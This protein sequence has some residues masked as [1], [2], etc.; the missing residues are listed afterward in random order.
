MFRCTT[1]RSRILFVFGLLVIALFIQ[2][3]QSALAETIK[4][5]RDPSVMAAAQET[6]VSTGSTITVE[7]TTL[8]PTSAGDP[9]DGACDLREAMQAA[10]TANSTNQHTQFNECQADPGPTFII[11][12]PSVAGQT[13]TLAHGDDILPFVNHELTITGPI[14][15]S[16]GGT[17]PVNPPPSNE[18]WDSRLFRTA[19]GGIFTLID[20]T[21]KKGFTVGG[22]GIILGSNNSTINLIGVSMMDNTVYG[23]GGAINTD[24]DLNILLSNFS[25]N[26]ALGRNSNDYT[27]N[28][29]TGFGGAIY[30]SGASTLSISLSNFSGN[31]A[32]KSGGAIAI[33]QGPNVSIADTNFLGNIAQADTDEF[34]GGGALYNYHGSISI[35]RS[36]FSANVTTNGRG[37]AIF[38]N[39]SAPALDISDSSF[40]ANVSGDNDTAGNGGAIYNEEDMTITRSTFNANVVLGDGLGGAITNNRAAVMK[41]TNTTFL[42]NA[43]VN[44]ISAA[45]KGGAIANIDNPYPVSSDTT[46]ELR[47]VTITENKAQ[48]GGGIYNE[49]LVQLW[50][51]IVDEGTVGG[52]GTCAGTAPEDKGHNL[53]N[54]GATCGATIN[55]TDP[56]LDV[57]KFNGGALAALVSRLPKDGSPAIDAGDNAVCDGPLVN[58]EDQRGSARPK[59]GD[60]DFSSACDI[61]AT[62]AGT[63]APGFGSDPVQPGPLA[64]GNAT[65]G[66]PATY[67]LSIIETGTRELTVAANISGPDAADFNINSVMP[68]VMPNGSPNYPLE[69]VCDPTSAT[70]GT[71]TATLSLTTSD[72]D[73]LTVDYDMTCVV[74]SVPTPGFGSY[75]EA[76]GPLD[77]GAVAVGTSSTQILELRETG[78]ADLSLAGYNLTGPNTADFTLDPPVTTLVDGA[79]PAPYQVTCTPTATGMRTAKL[80]ISTND[81][82]WPTAEFDLVCM[83]TAVQPTYLSAPGQALLTGTS[84]GSNG[85]YDVAVSPDSRFV[86]VTDYGD[87][88]VVA[89][90][91]NAFGGLELLHIYQDGVDGVSNLVQ[92]IFLTVSPD[93]RNLYVAAAGS[94]AIVTFSRDIDTGELAYM[95]AVVEGDGY[96]C[97]PIPCN[98]NINGLEGA[99]G[100][101]VSQDGRFVYVT[102]ITDDAL[103]VLRRNTT[104][105]DLRS[106]L[107][108]ANFVQSYTSADL[109]GV[110]GVTISPDGLHLYAAGFIGNDL[111]VFSRNPNDGQVTF[112]QARHD[113]DLISINPPRFL[114]GLAG[115]TN[116]VVSPDGAYVYVTGQVD[117][118]I[119]VFSRNGLDGTVTYLRSYDDD[120]G[121]GDGLAGA[122]GL[123]LSPD[124]HT[125]YATGFTDDSVV[126]F[127]REATTGLLK[128]LQTTT[129]PELDGAVAVAAAPDGT[130]VFALGYLQN[131]IVTLRKSNPAPQIDS[132]LPASAAG[133]SAGLT[134]T[135]RGQN[136]ASDSIVRWNGADR[137]ATYISPTELQVAVMAAD[138]PADTAVTT[139]S[140]AVINGTP[141]GGTA[142]AEFA[143]THGNELPIPAIDYISPQSLPAAASSAV[144]TVYGTNF[145][146]A[147]QVLWNGSARPT[148]YISSSELQFTISGDDLLNPG[149]AAISLVNQGS[150]VAQGVNGVNGGA[151]SNNSVAFTVAA[152]GQNPAPTITSL[153][154]ALS[155]ARGAASRPM[156]ILVTGH[157]FVEGVQAQWNGADRPTVL[158]SNTQLRVTL[159]AADLAFA[160]SG[161]LRVV[162]PE[163]GGGTSNTAALTIFPYGLFL[164]V[165]IR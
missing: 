26:V 20:I 7:T 140:V 46:V 160:G 33:Y 151:L 109:D 1:N 40:N 12:A 88:L 22:G 57:P 93:G 134:L 65:P 94:N 48:T 41:V 138:L 110:R 157:N 36:P 19:G 78:N 39:L 58:K 91:R 143:I 82:A 129:Q 86:Y 14:T 165:M 18:N 30:M 60:G 132:L 114:D 49:E 116:V 23:D 11:F 10:F 42:A 142:V 124:G 154:P 21:L 127:D 70:P 163:P 108:G 38:N 158:L 4:E 133:G 13:I 79:A 87:D 101:T 119:A 102:G 74:P 123:K 73:N 95:S 118:T 136:F 75:P 28:L 104:T 43:V 72:P 92:P 77:F 144:L 115:A 9:N 85:P 155:I 34:A 128:P 90:Q 44:G 164:P 113:G 83:G 131:R 148:T 150:S 89:F 47:N 69:L 25:N 37:G 53:Q 56:K 152:P 8:S 76:P 62:E 146:P 5:R 96:G 68:I 45:G 145:L 141:G 29:G 107:T 147:V 112:V 161:G 66:V 106:F 135:I 63:A 6:A 97:F 126:V 149:A 61:G 35:T 156:S 32:N 117:N 99:Y 137:E 81:P 80:N 15:L 125:L 52:G 51:T 121:S 50:N 17:P 122:F 159:T 3:S 111:A 67:T 139:A 64:F 2:A 16:G 55:S 98:G 31:T 24:G 100:V 153:T 130:A 59:D 71:R 27:N 162:N 54:P 103:V 105:G 120:D 84:A